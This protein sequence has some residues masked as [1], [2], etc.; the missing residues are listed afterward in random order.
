M[1]P[2]FSLIGVHPDMQ[3]RGLGVQL[4]TMVRC[5]FSVST[6]ASVAQVANPAWT[7]VCNLELEQSYWQPSHSEW[8]PRASTCAY[9]IPISLVSME[10]GMIHTVPAL[11]NDNMHHH[12]DMCMS[13]TACALWSRKCDMCGCVCRY[14]V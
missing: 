11:W 14:V 5:I 6:S 2:T 12:M 7:V 3:R 13:L 1:G 4:L 8:F 9:A 10:L